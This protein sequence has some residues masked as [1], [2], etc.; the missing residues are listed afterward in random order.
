MTF[1]NS[2]TEEHPDRG[3][4][5]VPTVKSTCCAF[6]LNFEGFLRTEN[7]NLSSTNEVLLTL[8]RD[9][10]MKIADD[11]NFLARSIYVTD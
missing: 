9:T 7:I 4:G 8:G 11:V 10:E 2:A 1:Y 3:A 6:N 5:V